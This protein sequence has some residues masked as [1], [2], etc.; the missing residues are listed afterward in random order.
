VIHLTTGQIVDAAGGRFHR[1]VG[2]ELVA[3][4]DGVGL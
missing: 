2:T 4:F 3:V 1:A